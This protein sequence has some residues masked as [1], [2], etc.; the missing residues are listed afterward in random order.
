MKRVAVVGAESTG[1]STLCARLAQHYQTAWVPEYGREYTLELAARLGAMDAIHWT[2][3]DFLQIAEGQLAAE[4]EAQQ[5]AAGLLICDTDILAVSIWQER[6][7]GTRNRAIEALASAHP[8]DL[9]LLTACD[10]P[11]V[12]DEIRDGEHFREWMTARFREVLDHKQLPFVELHGDWQQRFDQAAAAID[13]LTA[14]ASGTCRT[15]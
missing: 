13:R 12:A 6:Y 1:K 10:V 7:L 11:F 15:S 2:E 5:H 14:S 3:A 9:Y 8:I 4:K